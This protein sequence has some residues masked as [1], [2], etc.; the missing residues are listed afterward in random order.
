MK[1][2]QKEL[3]THPVVAC[4]IYDQWKLFGWWLSLTNLFFYTVFQVIFFTILIFLMPHP[5]ANDVNSC[6]LNGM[7]HLKLHM[8]LLVLLK[9]NFCSLTTTGND[10]YGMNN[11]TMI[12]NSTTENGIDIESCY[13]MHML[14]VTLNF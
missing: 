1:R 11:M 4:Y 6:C 5:L 14:T 12:I 7:L 2:K 3:L 8:Q 10:S 9:F 13:N